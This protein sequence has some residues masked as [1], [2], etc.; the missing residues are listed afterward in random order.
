MFH[1]VVE[2]SASRLPS[3]IDSMFAVA[4]DTSFGR[5][6]GYSDEEEVTGVRSGVFATVMVI[7]N[8]M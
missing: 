7:T 4:P 2:V 5:R 3:C 8:A 1:T 6:R